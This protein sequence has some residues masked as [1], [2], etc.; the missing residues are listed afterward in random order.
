MLLHFG[1]F[2]TVNCSK[3]I[4]H[5]GALPLRGLL[6]T[7]DARLCEGGAMEKASL[8]EGGGTAQAVTEGETNM[9]AVSLP[10]S[11]ASARQPPRQRGPIKSPTAN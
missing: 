8:W 2:Y 7:S 10:Q 6:R 1:I 11:R 9:K 4:Y 5:Y 3:P